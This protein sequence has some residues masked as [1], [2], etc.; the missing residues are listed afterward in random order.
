MIKISLLWTTDSYDSFLYK[1]LRGLD[2][3]I[4]LVC[5]ARSYSSLQ[6][7]EMISRYLHSI[8]IDK[9]KNKRNSI[10]DEEIYVF[11]YITTTPD[12]SESI[13]YKGKKPKVLSN[14]DAYP[15]YHQCNYYYFE[16]FVMP[17][18]KNIIWTKY[19]LYKMCSYHVT[20][21]TVLVV[22]DKC[23]LEKVFD[24]KIENG[25][26]LKQTFYYNKFGEIIPYYKGIVF[27][28]EMKY[29]KSLSNPSNLKIF[30]KKS[31]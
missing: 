10:S 2:T 30:L 29:T 20:D 31:L 13:E 18:I 24:V 11:P 23:F 14:I 6:T 21:Y 12:Y 16:E 17:Y 19:N 3:N 1:N 5:S 7:A 9:N 4:N 8:N 15:E 22:S 27:P 25:R 26:L 28:E